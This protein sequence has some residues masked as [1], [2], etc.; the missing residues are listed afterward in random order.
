MDAKELGDVLRFISKNEDLSQV[1]QA[2]PNHS[3]NDIRAGLASLATALSAEPVATP[4]GDAVARTGRITLKTDGGSRG[5]P[6]P[7]G[8]G[9]V[10]FDSSGKIVATGNEFLG[11]RTNNEAEYAAV[12][13]GLQAVFELG[14]TEVDVRLDSDLLVKQIKGVY[15]VKKPHLKPLHEQ[16]LRLLRQFNDYTIAHIYRDANKE[17]DEQANIAMDRGH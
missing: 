8:A 3:L 13:L 14:Y 6:G 17:A 15:R 11:K 5:N 16:A 2:F 9:W 7:S 1:Q 12:L 10:L 4:R